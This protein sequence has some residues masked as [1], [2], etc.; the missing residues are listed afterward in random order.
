MTDPK[1]IAATALRGAASAIA[2]ATI[3][4][5]PGPYS[6]IPKAIEAA[7]AGAAMLIEAESVDTNKGKRQIEAALT[8]FFD[9]L[10]EVSRAE[11]EVLADFA[12]TAT[13]IV[14]RWLR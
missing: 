7:A 14:R 12:T 9:T 2:L 3:A 13:R 5:K 11:S 6:W 8:P 10:P 4:V 1:Q